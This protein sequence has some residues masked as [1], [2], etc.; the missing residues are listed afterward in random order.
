MDKKRENPFREIISGDGE[1]GLAR[2]RKL[3]RGQA[4]SKSYGRINRENAGDIQ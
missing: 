3:P 4:Q 2:K 1:A